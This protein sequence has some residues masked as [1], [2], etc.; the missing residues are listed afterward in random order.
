[1]RRRALAV[2]N[3]QRLLRAL[4]PR[5]RPGRPL[6]V[7]IVGALL[8]LGVAEAG[9]ADALR[10]VRVTENVF[11]VVGATGPQTYE[12]RGLNTNLGFIVTDAGVVVVNSGPTVEV[13]RA[14]R[15][16]IGQV[17][18]RPIRLVINVNSQSHN[19]LGNA[20]YRQAGVPILAH[21]KAVEVMRTGG[22][23]Q[24]ETVRGIVRER[25]GGTTL[26]YPTQTIG[27]RHELVVGQTTIRLLH[28]GTAHTPGDLVV[29]LPDQRVA[30]AGD[31]VFVDRLPG[32]LPGGDS[33]QWVAAFDQMAALAPRVIVPG[34]GRPTDIATATTTTRDYLAYL[35]EQ[36]RDFIERGRS[37]QEAV[38]GIDQS[39]FRHLR[40][41]DLLSRRNVGQVYLEMEQQ[42]F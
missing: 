18:G 13:A 5:R 36:V 6:R 16:A 4:W 37:L 30:F 25:A 24:L 2:P 12:N 1:M 7:A 11:A 22:G 3:G 9:A 20:F 10:P 29:W 26:S 17:T 40:N 34:H 41:F 8:Q 33:G 32:V 42:L 28:F 27:D 39:R 21:A 23:A 15:A 19:W 14:L 35:R 31:L 38:E